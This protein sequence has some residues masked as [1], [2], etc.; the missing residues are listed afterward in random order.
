MLIFGVSRGPVRRKSSG[1]A[2]LLRSTSLPR[3]VWRRPRMR[4]WMTALTSM[5][6]L[7][8]EVD[9]NSIWPRGRFAENYEIKVY[10]NYY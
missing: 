9:D 5:E 3:V 8:V 2:R 10:N 7:P 6:V 1:P 4:R